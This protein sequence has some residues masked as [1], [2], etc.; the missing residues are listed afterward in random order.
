MDTTSFAS[1]TDF[2]AADKIHSL[3]TTAVVLAVASALLLP[4][5]LLLMIAAAI[6]GHTQNS[7]ESISAVL[8]AVGNSDVCLSNAPCT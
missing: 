8:Q 2:S 5:L 6:V 4:T 3:P 7:S 1:R